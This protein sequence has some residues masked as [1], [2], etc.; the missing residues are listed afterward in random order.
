MYVVK[1]AETTLLQKIRSFNV[2]EID[3]GTQIDCTRKSFF[4]SV[5][6]TDLLTLQ[7]VSIKLMQKI[8][9]KQGGVD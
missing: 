2:D 9:I 8:I 5:S 4:I 6:L 3:T 1:A 7:Y